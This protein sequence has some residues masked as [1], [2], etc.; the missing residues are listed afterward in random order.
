MTRGGR[1]GPQQR[2]HRKRSWK[3]SGLVWF[4]GAAVLLA[5][6]ILPTL[7][8]GGASGNHPDP[9]PASQRT[10]VEAAADYAGYPQVAQIYAEVAQ[11]PEV[12]DGV[13]CY[14]NCELH[15]GHYSLL[16][17]FQNEHASECDLCLAEGDLAF[18]MHQE[19]KSL[20]QIRGA[21]DRRY[22]A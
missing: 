1:T 17:C 2:P 10:R 12:V 11:V 20:D 3:D 15:A 16:D 7:R 5:L 6:L 22:G 18:R 9:R 19:G 13:Y 21:V 4:G 8:P 14:C